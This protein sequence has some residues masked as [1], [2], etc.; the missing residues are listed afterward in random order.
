MPELLTDEEFL[1]YGRQILL[2]E[3]GE[4]GQ[5]RLKKSKVL[6]VGLGG[7]GS[8]A[9][10]YLAAAGVGQLW[11]ADGDKV[12]SSNLQRQVLYRTAD[13]HQSKTKAAATHLKALNPAV[14][15][16]V[17]PA[18]DES[19]L[20]SIVPQVDAVLDCSDNMLTRQRVN[21]ACVAA[22][23]P[24]ITAAATGWD[25]QLLLCE[26]EQ[27]SVCYHCLFPSSTEPGLNCSTAGIVGPI[28]GML[29]AAQALLT[30]QL[31]CN[32]PRPTGV[33]QRF[34][35]R[36]LQWQRLQ[37]QPD[38]A[39]SVCQSLSSTSFSESEFPTCKSA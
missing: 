17:L 25:G 24:L 12:D 20:A 11:L 8:P 7:L 10:L 13:R 1:R 22:C 15:C 32:L 3:I 31:L 5:A 28:V 36:T 6:I 30:L 38:P 35:G 23:K 14:Q 37:T 26:P 39:C 29:G 21:A 2:P 18:V 27:H 9:S 16:H 34:D 4:A 19:L 33:L